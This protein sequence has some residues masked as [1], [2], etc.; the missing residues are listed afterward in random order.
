MFRH[1]SRSLTGRTA[2]PSTRRALSNPTHP[3]E[4]LKQTLRA[5]Q[6]NEQPLPTLR[7]LNTSELMTE[8]RDWYKA[9]YDAAGKS[10]DVRDDVHARNAAAGHALC[11][12]MD[13]VVH[14]SN[15]YNL[16]LKV[17][18]PHD[19]DAAPATDR[20]FLEQIRQRHADALKADFLASW[21]ANNEVRQ[22]AI[23]SVLLP[24]VAMQMGL[25][26]S[27]SHAAQARSWGTI[28]ARLLLSEAELLALVDYLN[29][30][31]GTFNAV[32]GAALANA[33]YG[34][35]V[36]QQIMSTFARSLDSAINKLCT[37]P[38]FG[39]HDIQTYKGIRLADESGPFRRS[40]LDAALGSQKMIVFPNVL[41]ATSLATKSY[42]ITKAELGYSFEL[43]IMMRTGFDADPFHDTQ[44][45][46]EG[47]ILGP[48][49]QRFIVAAKVEEEAY[50]PYAGRTTFIDRY[51][52]KPAD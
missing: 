51:V 6:H 1:L 26:S 5:L 31:T 39:K 40:M 45:M 9:E 14:L 8:V 7:Q 4:Q 3:V 29:S 17:R 13:A 12:A 37:H 15:K 52:L 43:G 25:T 10:G 30:T 46:G 16:T 36:L 23:L 11:Y 32:N 20:E 38:Y 42:A 33:Y 34:E 35:P 28:P 48:A 21:K 41:S 44:T 18:K 27:A 49:G 47:E 24:S 22:A 50:V 19:K 2:Q